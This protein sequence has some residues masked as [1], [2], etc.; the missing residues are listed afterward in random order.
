MLELR[1]RLKSNS[2]LDKATKILRVFCAIKRVENSL[3]QPYLQERQFEVLLLYFVYGYS[4]DTKNMVTDSLGISKANLSK[5]NSKL[6][7]QR[8][9]KRGVHNTRKGELNSELLGLKKALLESKEPTALKII[10]Q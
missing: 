6:F 1:S 10:F 9:L 3:K 4:V 8:L 2:Q 7:Q 5:I